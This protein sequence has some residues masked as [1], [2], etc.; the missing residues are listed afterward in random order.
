[1][2]TKA[3]L[4]DSFFKGLQAIAKKRI[5]SFNNHHH[6]ANEIKSGR[7]CFGQID[8]SREHREPDLSWV[9]SLERRI[10]H[11]SCGSDELG[12]RSVMML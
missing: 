5:L 11:G 6:T 8:R 3:R 4:G 10:E 9:S 1:V 7:A 12:P 2:R